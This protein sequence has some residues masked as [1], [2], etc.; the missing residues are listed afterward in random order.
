MTNEPTLN[1]CRNSLKCSTVT[2]TQIT[3]SAVK[4]MTRHL[5]VDWWQNFKFSL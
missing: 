5:T 4:Q 1:S 3:S 2:D